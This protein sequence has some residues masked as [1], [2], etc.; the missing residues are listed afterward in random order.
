[1][2]LSEAELNVQYILSDILIEDKTRLL[3]LG[4]IPDRPIKKVYESFDKKMAAI[5]VN[6]DSGVVISLRKSVCDKIIVI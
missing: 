3:E 1:M 6:R 5:E 2:T 4:F